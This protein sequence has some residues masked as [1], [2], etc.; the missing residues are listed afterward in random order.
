[1]PMQSPTPPTAGADVPPTAPIADDSL[2]MLVGRGVM[3][4]GLN[5]LTARLVSVLAQIVCA[6]IL[7]PEDFGLMGLAGTVTG[8]LPLVEQ[9]GIS[10]ALVQRHRHLKRWATPAFWL[11]LGLGCV[12]GCVVALLAPVA[13]GLYHQPQLVPLILVLA[14]GCP[15]Q[16]LATVPQASLA[17]GLEFRTLAVV[18]LLTIVVQWGLAIGM[19]LAGCGA[20]SLAVPPVAVAPLRAGVLWWVARPPLRLGAAGRQL[21]SGWRSLLR[22]SNQML[23]ARQLQN[24]VVQGDYVVLGLLLDERQVGYYFLAFTLATQTVMLLA[25]NLNAA[26]FPALSAIR[27]DDAHVD[28]LFEKSARLLAALSIPASALLVILAEPLVRVCFG[29]QWE[30]AIPLLQ[31]LAA[32]MGVFAV[33]CAASSVLYARRQLRLL[34]LLGGALAALFFATIVPAVWYAGAFGA[35]CAESVYY[36][37]GQG[38]YLYFAFS[39]ARRSLRRI[40]GLLALP[41]LLA[42]CILP[43]G[44]AVGW[45]LSA[46]GWQGGVRIAVTTGLAMLVWGLFWRSVD[47][48]PL[49]AL[50]AVLRRR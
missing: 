40:A 32:G 5:T 39:P 26:L 33:S 23:L 7:I 25:G 37:V 46:A 43:L 11:T 10:E 14:V 44:P 41:L 3:W 28:R 18:S 29:A 20:Y 22:D 48:R 21:C 36:A 42:L 6:W 4:L 12:A 35:A 49:E 19:A 13:A 47:S 38:A 27:D 45:W 1:M 17:G 15:L 16:A 34:I 9:S 31:M 8:F 50:R 2:G 30:P 24:V